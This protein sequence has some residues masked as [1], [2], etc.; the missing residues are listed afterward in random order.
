MTK[1][2]LATI[3]KKAMS[4]GYCVS[5]GFRHYLYNNAVCVDNNGNRLT[6]FDVFD[7]S[8]NCSVWGCYNNN[9]DHLWTLEEVEKFIRTE[10]EKAGL[11]Y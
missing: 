8:T 2:S 9:F 5:K 3:K 1:Y 7:L 6:G 10:Y 4:A 11:E